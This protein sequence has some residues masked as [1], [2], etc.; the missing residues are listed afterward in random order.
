MKSNYKALGSYIREVSQINSD[1]SVGYL[2]GISSVHKSFIKS[3]AN[4]VGVDFLDYKIVRKNQFAFN[5]NTARMGDRI[6][7]ALNDSED[8]IVSKIYPVFEVLDEDILLPEYLMLWFRRPEFDRY[9]RFKSHGSAREI[10]DWDQMCN[11]TLPIPSI[12]TQKEVVREFN[13][14]NSK[15]NLNL[16]L[17]DTY[18]EAAQAIYKRWFIDFDFPNENGSP[19]KSSGGIMVS[20]DVGDIP[21]SWKLGN[22]G[23]VLASKGYIRGPFG[24]ALKKE[25]MINSGLPVY[26]QQHAIDDHRDFRYFISTEKHKALNRFTVRPKDFV[27]S[28]SGTLGKIIMIKESDPIGVINQALLIL[29][30]DPS[31]FEPICLKYFLTS[32]SGNQLLIENSSGSAQLNIA[33]REVIQAIPIVIPT[34]DEQ[35]KVADYLFK[36]E[37]SIELLKSENRLL[38]ELQGILLSKIATIGN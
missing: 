8:C 37:Q 13:A 4:I 17:I 38:L 12:E 7:I 3:K 10:F 25:D 33:K 20:T 2:R 11:V 19:Y 21:E 31:K 15:L 32:A 18:E 1:L 23:E 24:S 27:I 5:P 14:V 16:N 36:C 35:R 26:E 28:C 6:P 9:A 29:R 30:V 22:L 34:P